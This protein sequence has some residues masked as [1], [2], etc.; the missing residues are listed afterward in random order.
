VNRQ[1]TTKWV[2]AKA[3]DY[4]GDDWGDDYNDEP[5]P[6]PEPEVAPKATGLRQPGQA[7]QSNAAGTSTTGNKKSYGNLP[8]VPM[9]TQ[10]RSATTNHVRNNS[11]GYDDER[12]AFSSGTAQQ[13]VPPPQSFDQMPLPKDPASAPVNPPV[14][15]VSTQ[16]PAVAGLRKAVSQVS[17]AVTTTPQSAARSTINEEPQSTTSSRYTDTSKQT[18]QS[19]VKSPASDFHGRR[20]FSPTA[21]PKLAQTHYSPISQSAV[22]ETSTTR[23]PPRKSS[24]SSN[25]PDLADISRRS[26][27][28]KPWT[29]PR[30]ASPAGSARSL[31]SEK[32]A[33]PFI[34]PADI[35]KRM[36][37]EKERERQSM[38]SSRPS[39]D[40]IL[41]PKPNEQLTSSSRVSSSGLRSESPGASYRRGPSSDIDRTSDYG[42]RTV[43]EPVRERKSEY[44]LDGFVPPPEPSNTETAQPDTAGF[45]PLHE[46]HE[47]EDD[48][49][50]FSTSPKLPDL[51]RMSGFG[52]DMFSPP[53]L[54][55]EPAPTAAKEITTVAS[56]AV[57]DSQLRT[58]PSLGFTS[59]VHQAFDDGVPGTPA[60][61]NASGSGVGRTDSNSTGTTGISPI[62]SRVPSTSLAE[63]RNRDIDERQN[64]TTPAIEE[65]EEPQSRRPSSSALPASS[66]DRQSL[67]EPSDNDEEELPPAIRPGH[68]R[69]ISTPSPGNSPA[70]TPHVQLSEGQ[71]YRFGEE[72]QMTELND[73]TVSPIEKDQQFSRP[74]AER[75]E[76][77]RPALPGGW[78]SYATTASDGTAPQENGEVQ[79]S[80]AHVTA[81]SPISEG[82]DDLELT[83]TTNK[84]ASP[85]FVETVAGATLSGLGKTDRSAPPI[86]VD[87]PAVRQFQPIVQSNSQ[88]PTPDP[89]LAPIGNPY[90]VNAVDPRL[91]LPSQNAASTLNVPQQPPHD[92]SSAS[93]APPTPPP[94]DT[95]LEEPQPKN[96]E[97]FPP[98]VPLKQRPHD[99]IVNEEA[100]TPVRPQVLPTLSTA[101]SP[102]DEENDKLRKEIVKSLSPIASDAGYNNPLGFSGPEVAEDAS[103]AGTRESTYLP[104]I[105]DSY[106][107]DGTDPQRGQSSAS[108]REQGQMSLTHTY[109]HASQ[110][111]PVPPI[112]PLNAKRQ[113]MEHSRPALLQNRFSWEAGQE[114]QPLV[115]SPADA[116]PVPAPLNISRPVSTVATPD[117]QFRQLEQAREAYFEHGPIDSAGQ[118]PGLEV[119]T[120]PTDVPVITST[121]GKPNYD[122]VSENSL[123]PHSEHGKDAALVSGGI[124]AGALAG[125]AYV[126]SHANVGEPKSRR[127]SLAEEKN[128]ANAAA[129][130]VTQTPPEDQHPARSP[131]PDLVSPIS[132]QSSG[133]SSLHNT[134]PHETPQ[135]LNSQPSP[136][137]G[138]VLQFKEILNIQNPSNRLK[139][140]NDTRGQFYNMDTG[141]SNWLVQMGEEH[142]KLGEPSASIGKDGKINAS[143][144]AGASNPTS[145]A[146]P[147]LAQPYYQQYL[148][149]QSSPTTAS[150]PTTSGPGAG[151]SSGQQGFSS[152]A[153]KMSTQQV[154]AKSKELLHTAGI[155]GGKG[156]KAGKG[157]LAK[158]KSRFRGSGGDKVD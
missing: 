87:L 1:K 32:K 52:M 72:A 129:Y 17:P 135:P 95:P 148:N 117:S 34:R 60:S 61:A 154:Q 116:S 22:S 113:S 128:P 20:D 130:A 152:G 103:G 91:Q 98:T 24:I 134:Q 127:L 137:D 118:T 37:E 2:Q 66:S 102:Q 153:G 67:P 158:G 65:V 131:Q 104:S 123:E 27:D 38:D 101:T 40:S 19:E 12:R 69:N 35:Y 92:V 90:S 10:P 125:A 7:V 100:S 26:Q 46:R 47:S 84:R 31:V 33:L 93:S 73:P 141:L 45:E 51:S 151:I 82:E 120:K 133:P 126:G 109:S 71:R 114:Q 142:R 4:G 9:E 139:A 105:Y 96:V 48:R 41:G 58:Q 42:Q 59:V 55:P 43:L 132:L 115:K 50:R 140:Y 122:S 23:F 21:A 119:S 62:M 49:R 53:K 30:S 81:V 108:R 149:A 3:P 75:E 124:A 150:R 77:F 99:E 107:E 78:V 147:A 79:R 85:Q 5:E 157:L 89:A 63:T 11:F 94:K 155:F 111:E 76:S 13:T 18:E 144:P 110:E 138:K 74:S 64:S 16:S 136:D 145:P 86:P 106:W 88:L 97:Y 68:R 83:P 36:E 121:I 156:M 14:L 29:E 28:V 112:P 8:S 54:D 70:R 15:H 143:R 57:D 146:S 56:P 6:E 44:G 39:M 80:E 25:P